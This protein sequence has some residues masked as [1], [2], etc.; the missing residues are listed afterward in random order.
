MGFPQKKKTFKLNKSP[1]ST[2]TPC[3][4]ICPHNAPSM[5]TVEAKQQTKNATHAHAMQNTTPQ[6]HGIP[7]KTLNSKI[8]HGPLKTVPCENHPPSKKPYQTKWPKSFVTSR[9]MANPAKRLESR[10]LRCPQKVSRKFWQVLQHLHRFVHLLPL[11][12]C[13]VF[14]SGVFYS[15]VSAPRYCLHPFCLLYCFWFFNK[16]DVCLEN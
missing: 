8:R 3:K 7:R 14:G 1:I 10:P 4:P 5:H 6:S 2:N 12:P 16:F 13:L 9:L 11:C 15:G